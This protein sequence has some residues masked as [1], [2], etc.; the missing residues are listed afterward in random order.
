[1]SGDVIRLFR[2]PAEDAPQP[3]TIY[4]IDIVSWADGTL[5]VQSSPPITSELDGHELAHILRRAAGMIEH[6]KPRG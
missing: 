2:S 4:S 3:T 5:T 6:Q 1:M